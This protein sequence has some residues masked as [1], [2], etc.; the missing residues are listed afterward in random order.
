M[1]LLGV[2]SGAG[3]DA[4]TKKE[5][6]RVEIKCK[7]T[8]IG[9]NNIWFRVLDRTGMEFICAV[10]L[11]GQKKPTKQNPSSNFDYS[12]ISQNI[13]VLSSFNKEKDSGQYSCAT[14]KNVEL[15]FGPVTRLVGGELVSG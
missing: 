5:G 13:L 1:C 8:E 15:V 11:N 14:Y 7:T 12:K 6:E 2:T 3:N 9:S 10:G 4:I